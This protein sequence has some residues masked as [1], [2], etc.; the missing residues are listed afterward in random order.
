MGVFVFCVFAKTTNAAT[1]L[2]KGNL[3]QYQ[4]VLPIILLYPII[5]YPLNG[6]L[7]CMTEN[8][9][10]NEI[11]FAINSCE[12]MN[13]YSDINREVLRLGILLVV[14]II[15]FLAVNNYVMTTAVGK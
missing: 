2:M 1:S 6:Q 12:L 13:N 8:R 3:V 9:N 15:I 11:K 5:F 14:M 10:K 7:S 4:P